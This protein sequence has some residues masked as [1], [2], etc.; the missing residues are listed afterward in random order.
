VTNVPVK[1]VAPNEAS[2][3]RFSQNR[4][5]SVPNFEGELCIKK[6]VIWGKHSELSL[7][8]YVIKGKE[9]RNGLDT[10]RKQAT[11]GQNNTL[12]RPQ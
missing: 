4:K 12:T 7:L 1:Q 5:T 10:P 2:W 11:T 6:E 3:S 9:R 8:G